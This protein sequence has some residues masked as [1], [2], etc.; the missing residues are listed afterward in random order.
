MIYLWIYKSRGLHLGEAPLSGSSLCKTLTSA[1][2]RPKPRRNKE[3]EGVKK[4][5]SRK[6]AH[7]YSAHYPHIFLLFLLL[8]EKKN[9][10]KPIRKHIK[11]TYSEF[12]DHDMHVSI[13]V[14]GV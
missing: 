8:G 11:E 1:P 12:D 7:L 3:K 2:K 5:Y 10:K 4:S 14:F 13:M 6:D 9:P